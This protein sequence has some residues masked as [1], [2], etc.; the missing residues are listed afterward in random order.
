MGMQTLLS[1]VS[2]NNALGN[3]EIRHGIVIDDCCPF[4]NISVC[5]FA[6][7]QSN[8]APAPAPT[9]YDVVQFNRHTDSS[10]TESA[11]VMSSSPETIYAVVKKKDGLN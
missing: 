7:L 10:S 5:V 8:A 3:R 2:T 6:F 4:L 1:T 11:P 9:V